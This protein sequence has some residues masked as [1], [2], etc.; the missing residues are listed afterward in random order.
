[1]T[2]ASSSSIREANDPACQEALGAENYYHFCADLFLQPLD[3]EDHSALLDL[4]QR[5]H[6]LLEPF[7]QSDI[8]PAKELLNWSNRIL[9]TDDGSKE[10]EAHATAPGPVWEEEQRALATDR[11]FLFRSPSPSA[12]RPPYESYY[13][14]SSEQG[15]PDTA[16]MADLQRC[17]AEGDV[18][19]NDALGERSDYLGIELAFVAYCASQEYNALSISDLEQ[20][21]TWR[22]LRSRFEEEHLR[23]WVPAWAAQTAPAAR[24]EF[25]RNFVLLLGAT[26]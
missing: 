24:T 3:P 13:R 1:M 2:E 7:T 8:E 18:H 16:L 26:C 10:K 20:A 21:Q 23:S 11:T 25:F 19:P 22:D 9:A 5:T 17:Y 6:R 4:A 12:P 14:N 15:V